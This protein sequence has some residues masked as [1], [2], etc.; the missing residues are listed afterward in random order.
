MNDVWLDGVTVGYGRSQALHSVHVRFPEGLTCL[1]GLNGAGK[2]T[3]LRTIAGDLSPR[4]GVIGIGQSTFT[5]EAPRSVH[6]KVAYLPQDPVL[7]GQMLVWDVVTYAAW[8]KRVSSST[9]VTEALDRVQLLERRH[10][11]CSALSGGLRRRAA[12]ACALVGGPEVVLLD[13]PTVGLDPEQR[14]QLRSIVHDAL[15]GSTVVISTHE[16][17]EVEALNAHIVLLHRGRVAFTG[18]V[19]ELRSAAPSSS[20]SL[21]EAF[22]HIVSG[23]EAK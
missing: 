18:T 12:L 2:T 4:A 9:A 19:A 5:T 17:A 21:E 22:T 6:S 23:S 8:L 10:D 3:L 13:E 1:L 7:P 11:R 15:H 20:A 16:L 14:L